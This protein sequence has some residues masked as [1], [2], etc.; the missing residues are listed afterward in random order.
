MP[1]GLKNNTK[2]SLE[3]NNQAPK[4]KANET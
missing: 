2:K 3:N 4:A 1:L